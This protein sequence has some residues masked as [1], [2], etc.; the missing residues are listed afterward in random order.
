M[1]HAVVQVVAVNAKSQ[2]MSKSLHNVVNAVQLFKATL[3]QVIQSVVNVAVQ[4]LVNSQV[5]D[6]V[7]AVYVVVQPPI[8]RLLKVNVHQD[9]FIITLLD[10]VQVA[11]P[12]DRV[13]LA[14]P[15]NSI[16]LVQEGVEAEPTLSEPD[17][18]ILPVFMTTAPNRDNVFDT[19]TSESKVI[20][21]EPESSRK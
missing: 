3:F 10:I 17:N 13:A 4:V 9:L 7:H 19:Y 6:V 12:D 21:D 14:L 8:D 15:V 2:A 16:S 18:H 5:Q 11:D 1:N 20:V